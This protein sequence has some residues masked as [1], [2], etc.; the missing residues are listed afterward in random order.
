M[1]NAQISSAPDRL[2]H[3]HSAAARTTAGS[4]LQVLPHLDP[5]YGGVTAVVP[6][7][8]QQLNS[9]E[10]VS[11]RLAAFCST[12]EIRRLVPQTSDLSVWPLARSAW[13]FDS[14]LRRQFSELIA[15]VDGVHIHGLWDS[16]TFF[17]ASAARKAGVPYV[18][19]AH[20]MLETWALANKR[21]KKALY[22]ALIEHR[23]VAG[24]AC[25]HALTH[26]EALDY[27]KFG[28][29]GPIAIIPNGVEAQASA[30]PSL[31]FERYPQA[32]GKQLL[33]FLGR[34]HYKKGV[35]LLVKAWGEIADLYPDA[36]LILA[37]PD[38]EG[39][40][41]Q[42]EQSVIR[43]DIADRVVFTG[44][45]DSDLKWSALAAASYFVLPSYSEGLSVA[46]LEAISMGV[47]LI[48]SEQCNL[49]QVAT[50]RAGW[51][52]QTSVPSLARALQSALGLSTAKRY[53]FSAEA[54]ALARREFGWG[55]ITER[56]AEL[57]RWVRG[58][59]APQNVELLRGDS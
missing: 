9:Q 25:L 2:G 16:S 49:P 27:R 48:V 54:K 43:L 29:T 24:A 14:A 36:L 12:D 44:M 59:A 26:A 37:G 56:M 35:D 13:A 55:P 18:L 47:P 51:L 6:R 42:V 41:A 4:W 31:F 34:I 30:S 53:V 3:P 52:V 40:L 39:T 19:S 33:L 17:A 7:L 50:S 1:L 46:A 45:L 23:N 8:T 22:A 15:S 58:G 38:S 11:A 32:Q 10:D 21:L 28:Y 5:V 57:Y 20:G